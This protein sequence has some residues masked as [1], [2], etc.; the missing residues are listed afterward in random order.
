MKAGVRYIYSSRFLIQHMGGG[1][2]VQGVQMLPLE[3]V[4][5]SPLDHLFRRIG[6]SANVEIGYLLHT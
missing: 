2:L 1:V 3:D 6:S 4:S 5:L